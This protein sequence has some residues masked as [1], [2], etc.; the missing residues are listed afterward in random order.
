MV[1]VSTDSYFSM[2]RAAQLQALRTGLPLGEEHSVPVA[3][4]QE[5]TS[6]AEQT[7]SEL[8]GQIIDVQV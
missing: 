2:V 4:A 6:P 3:V 8:I 7:A 1:T 5:A